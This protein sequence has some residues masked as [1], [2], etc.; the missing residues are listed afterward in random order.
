MSSSSA[1]PLGRRRCR[2][3]GALATLLGNAAYNA[4]QP[5][6]LVGPVVVRP[7]AERT[8]SGKGH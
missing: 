6:G 2:L 4:K 3:A 7:Y 1:R 8:V 5:Y